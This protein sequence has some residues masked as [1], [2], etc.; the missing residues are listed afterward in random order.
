MT[1]G[2]EV[3]KILTPRFAVTA[4]P[5][6]QTYGTEDFAWAVELSVTFS[7]YR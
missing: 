3:G 6:I 4:K 5:S 2:L 7:F 1:L